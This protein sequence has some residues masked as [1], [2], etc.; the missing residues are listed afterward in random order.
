MKNSLFL[1]AISAFISCNTNTDT[2]YI[3]EHK[4]ALKNMMHKGDLSAKADLKDFK[5][6][7]N[8]YAIGAIENLKGEVQIFNS[9][10]YNTS[11]DSETLVFDNTFN[12]KACLL[13]YASVK[14]WKSF[15]IPEKI[16]SYEQLEVYVE[17][18][19]SENGIN[20]A[21]PF[22]FLMEGVAAS[23][24]WH[25]I[26]WK[27]GDTE[28]SHEKHI[29]SGL[30]GTELN[31][32]V[33]MLGFY[34]DAHHAIFTHHTTNMHIHAKTLDNKLAGHIDA[35]TLGKDMILKLPE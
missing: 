2:K 9:K 32:K 10:S 26:N 31:T 18:I 27:D 4:G 8:L 7:E 12:K 25:I 6:I 19:A 14:K 5:K 21:E 22:P 11:V 24:D 34:S 17:K 1:I 13:V 33:E 20:T 29:K 15:K 3:V 23:F 35:L 16:R 28:H 30:Y